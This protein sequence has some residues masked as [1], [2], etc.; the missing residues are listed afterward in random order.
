M[1]ARSLPVLIALSVT[2]GLATSCGDESASSDCI[3]KAADAYNDVDLSGL[4]AADGFSEQEHELF[5]E[6]VEARL[7]ADP[8]L[9]EGGRCRQ[10]LEGQVLPEIVDRLDS[11]AWQA[12]KASNEALIADLN[13]RSS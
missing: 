10:E 1:T 8:E 9:A 6:R 2:V 3:D 7:A 13:D 5:I 12:L 11:D 4:S